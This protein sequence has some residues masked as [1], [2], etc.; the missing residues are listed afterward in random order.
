M[1]PWSLS[2]SRTLP[3]YCSNLSKRLN[4]GPKIN[5]SINSSNVNAQREKILHCRV[6]PGTLRCSRRPW[7]LDPSNTIGQEITLITP[8]VPYLLPA[9]F[10]M[11]HWKCQTKRGILQEIM[12]NRRWSGKTELY[13][14][15][16]YKHEAVSYRRGN[17]HNIVLRGSRMWVRECIRSGDP[18]SLECEQM[19]SGM[20]SDMDYDDLWST[21]W[22]V[23]GRGKG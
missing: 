18:L 22:G 8:S 2:F 12:R 10:H 3:S 13:R 7:E 14:G 15:F 11:K 4:I 16:C 20:A 23:I 9:I 6:F 1:Q 19:I 21:W 5:P 17:R